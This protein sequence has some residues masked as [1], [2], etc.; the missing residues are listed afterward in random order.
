M[1]VN[2]QVKPTPHIMLKTRDDLVVHIHKTIKC[3]SLILDFFL[4]KLKKK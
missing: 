2:N 3:G 1:L 4:F